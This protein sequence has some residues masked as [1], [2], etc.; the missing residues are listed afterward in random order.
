VSTSSF[1]HDLFLRLGWEVR[2]TGYPTSE[3][4]ILRQFLSVARPTVVFD[5]GAN[6]G[7][8]G[9]SLRKCGFAGRIVSFEAIPSVH[10]RLSAV[11]AKDQNWIV[12]PCSALG[13]APGEIQINRAANSVSSSILQMSDIH[14]QAAPDSRYVDAETVRLERLDDA[15]ASLLPRDGLVFLKIDT[16]GYEEE[17]LAGA[18]EVLTN[19]CALQLEMSI[20]PLYH[21]APS[22]RRILDLSEML[23][24]QLHGLLPGFH[25]QKSGALLQIDGLFLR[26]DA[27]NS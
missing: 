6:V 25:D 24:F 11:A 10:A 4:A 18:S 5:V 22:L 23:G 3:D 14:L 1:V 7:Q 19:V 2:R 13:R 17:V 26:T 12:A 15:A 8:Y 16:Q 20:Q 27:L 9:L 21:G